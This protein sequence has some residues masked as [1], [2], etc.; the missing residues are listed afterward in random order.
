M[1]DVYHHIMCL[2]Y[3]LRRLPCSAPSSSVSLFTRATL[4]NRGL[5]GATL[6][7]T[8]ALDAAAKAS[9]LIKNWQQTFFA[10]G[11]VYM[12]LGATHFAL[13][14]AYTNI[15]PPQGTWGL[16][17]LPGSADFHVAWAAGPHKGC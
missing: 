10:L 11:A 8:A 2:V 1:S 15:F 6:A 14:S 17:Y 5:G 3:K 7:T 13:P 12:L 9:P 16:W 4:R